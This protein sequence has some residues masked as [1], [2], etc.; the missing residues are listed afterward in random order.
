MAGFKIREIL[1]PQCVPL[2]NAIVHSTLLAECFKDNRV[3]YAHMDTKRVI[4]ERSYNSA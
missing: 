1:E 2:A 4:K 3:P